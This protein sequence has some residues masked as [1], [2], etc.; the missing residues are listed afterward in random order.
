MSVS[1]SS[2]V[3][4]GSLKQNTNPSINT[5]DSVKFLN[6]VPAYKA[7]WRTDV[8]DVG[9]QAHVFESFLE[10]EAGVGGCQ[11]PAAIGMPW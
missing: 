4:L 5:L 2:P 1:E 8:P 7:V 11:F 9:V 6:P 10:L 3:C